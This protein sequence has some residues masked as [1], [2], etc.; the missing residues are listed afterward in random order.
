MKKHMKMA[1]PKWNALLSKLLQF[2]AS[3]NPIGRAVLFSSI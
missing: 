1:F 2:D 3:I